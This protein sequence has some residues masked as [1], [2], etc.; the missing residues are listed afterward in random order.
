MS[1]IEDRLRADAQRLRARAADVAST[2]EALTAVRDSGASVVR[3]DQPRPN[4]VWRGT[5]AAAVIVLVGV[6]ATL[7]LDA[8]HRRPDSSSRAVVVVPGTET[9]IGEP[10]TT[11]VPPDESDPVTLPTTDEPAG[12][13]TTAPGPTGQSAPSGTAWPPCTHTDPG[14]R[15]ITV[16]RALTCP[17][18]TAVSVTGTLVTAADGTMMLCGSVPAA[19]ATACEGAG[20]H[21]VGDVHGTDARFG[22]TG[23]KQ[24]A[25]LIV[26]GG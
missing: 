24:G 19:D 21:V 4:R 25:E 5:A 18:G 9:E 15:P 10:A 3:I 2:E 20:L 8:D 23:V 6:G 12:V 7:F 17:D 26:G 16:S 14:R 1:E 11:L 22:I 13:P